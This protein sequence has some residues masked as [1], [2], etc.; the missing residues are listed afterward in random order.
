MAFDAG[1]IEATLTLNRNPFTAGLQAAKAQAAEFKKRNKIEIDIKVNL[2]QR[3]MMEAEALL[4]RLNG[5]VAKATAK[6]L[7]DRLQ[8]DKLLVDLK[9][10]D[11]HTYSANVDVDTARATADVIAFRTLLASLNDQTINLS[12]NTRA[13][14][15]A[16]GDGFGNGSS[17][18]SKMASLII[19]GLPIIA[20]AFTAT[21]GA[22][23]ALV[24]AL[25]IAGV[26][27]G[28]F[29]LVAV[30]AFKEIKAAV[31]GGQAAIDK[32]PPGLRLAANAMK[33]LNTEYKAL[34][35]ANEVATG[36]ALQVWFRT[37]TQLLK[38]LNPLVHA[39]ADAFHEVGHM[40]LDFFEAPWWEQFVGFLSRSIGP[41]LDM[42]FRS[43]F[44]VIKIIGNL[45]Q[46]FWDLGGS[47]IMET[48][49]KG[50]EE[51]AAYT[52]RI[53]NNKSFQEF[54]DAAVRS[55]P[56]V[57]ALLGSL[58]EFILKLAIG[59]EPLGSLIIRVLTGIFDTLNS[60]PIPV[61][62]AIAL[63]LASVWAAMA[64]GAAGPVGL[65]IGVLVG[66]GVIFADVLANS[67]NLR[68]GI[69]NLVNDIRNFFLPIWQVVVDNFNTKIKPAWDDL[70]ARV[71]NGVIPA[72]QRFWK[73]IQDEVLP[74][75]KPFVD[76]I[77]GTV[78][79]A[80][81]RFL[82]A[83]NN[84]VT[85]LIDMFGPTVAR[86]LRDAVTVFDGAFQMIAGLLDIFTGIFTAD[87]T[88][89][90]AGIQR[91]TEGF[92]T[93]VAGMFG[94]NLD[95][96][97]TMFTN[98]DTWLSTTWNSFWNGI[99]SFFRGIWD[100]FNL[101]VSAGFDLMTGNVSSAA[102]KIGAAWRKVANLF[103]DPINWV[104]RTVI[105]P[106]GGLAGGWNTVMG[107]IGQPQLS[108]QAPPQIP[109]F[110][111][112]GPVKG[113]GNGTADAIIA[114]VSNG[115]F[116]VREGIASKIMPFLTA[117]NAGQVEAMQAA[118]AH[119]GRNI[120]IPGFAGGGVVA[121]QQFAQSQGGPY[122]WGGVG[123]NG[124]DCSGFQSAIANVALGQFPYRRRFATASFAGG[125][126]AGG[127][128][129]GLNSAYGIGV[130]QGNPGHMAG[131]IGGLNAES[132]GGRGAHTGPSARGATN[133]MFPQRFSLPQ[134]GGAFIDGGAGG[135]PPVS[136][137][138]IIADKVTSLIK[139]VFSGSIPGVGGAIGQAMNTIPAAMVEKTVAAL[140]TKLE[141]LMTAAGS[142][143]NTI[144]QS[145]ADNPTATMGLADRG[146]IIPPGASTLFNATGRPEPLTNLDVYERMKPQGLT[147]EDVI[148]IMDAR[149]GRGDD[150]GDTYN[151]MLPE[152]AS[153]REL[154]DT[155]AFKKK[156]VSKGRYSR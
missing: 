112:G 51:F 81:I 12:A 124:Y 53:G 19:A 16:A 144:G 138:S 113:P 47:Q 87:W 154:A 134:A 104:I 149:G 57:G 146:A 42:L 14:G 31:A 33:D 9:R 109:A 84:I 99:T 10:F 79:P 125:G 37:A 39:A 18:F 119:L 120:D 93:V 151:V 63:A 100:T 114:A 80:I 59:L 70:I 102:D 103:R 155:M 136:W 4:K 26:G 107:W 130:V 20:S 46:A 8:F 67:N 88:T 56:I 22:V 72:L 106:P 65:A 116:I 108:V 3:D 40:A 96:L 34:Q 145:L 62:Q 36:I 89:F 2:Q 1:S 48:I 74:T 7:V 98:W 25:L 105:G 156:V 64:M 127:F 29:A 101:I 90:S 129:P 110:A 73:V 118:G 15:G 117:L 85:F 28:A 94:T 121:A 60:L 68:G 52:E 23:G 153:V 45:T 132:S 141:G 27:A 83:L 135:A 24:S 137:W 147:A 152:R 41:A 5:Q 128:V 122:V 54:M 21:V 35:K 133:G 50:L 77:T 97:R 92:W 49:T 30:P 91:L 75:L 69:D 95:G 66:L 11:G 58:I 17:H 71:N 55:L 38:T 43:L 143:I 131:T 86:E 126:G 111:S 13:F 142:A 76:T 61:I 6:I 139:G 148:A 32:L 150:G 123:P 140:K 44:A 78:I 82:G 115:E